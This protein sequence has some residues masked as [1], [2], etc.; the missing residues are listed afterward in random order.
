MLT[1]KQKEADGVMTVKFREPLSAQACV[2][3]RASLILWYHL[4]IDR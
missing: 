1:G 2:I 3:V 4:L